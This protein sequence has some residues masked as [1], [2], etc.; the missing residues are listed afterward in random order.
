MKKQHIVCAMG[1]MLL[2]AGAN[3]ISVNGGVGRD[4]TFLGAGLGTETGG[5]YATGNYAHNDDNGDIFGLGVGVNIPLGPMMA[6]LGGKGVYL[7]PKSYKEGYALAAGGGIK[8]P[9]TSSVA[10][11]G[12]YYYSP[13]SLSSHVK[14][15]TEA[16]AGLSWT[17]MRPFSVEGGYRYISMGGKHG[18]KTRTV[19]DGVYLGASVGF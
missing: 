8:W 18:D 13:D 4:F 3:A 16:Q 11:F 2:S 14:D 12:D 15:Y 9:V 6:S 10:L 5:L 1:L 17:I 19:A 7:N